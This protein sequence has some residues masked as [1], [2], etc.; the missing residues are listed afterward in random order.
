MLVTECSVD[1][2]ICDANSVKLLDTTQDNTYLVIQTSGCMHLDS[3]ADQRPIC[4]LYES[5]SKVFKF[6]GDPCFIANLALRIVGLLY[7]NE[8]TSQDYICV[9]ILDGLSRQFL[10]NDAFLI[11][12]HADRTPANL[13]RGRIQG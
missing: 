9:Y 4:S 3:A 8:E 10:S 13:Q 12:V 11:N 2:C 7:R 6:C 1:D 5:S